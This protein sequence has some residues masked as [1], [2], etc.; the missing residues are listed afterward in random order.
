ML[1]VLACLVAG[2]LEFYLNTYNSFQTSDL[3]KYVLRETVLTIGAFVLTLAILERLLVNR[4]EVKQLITA[5]SLVYLLYA[6]VLLLA[7]ALVYLFSSSWPATLL[8]FGWYLLLIPAAISL[9]LIHISHLRTAR[10]ILLAILIAS[11]IAIPSLLQS[12]QLQAMLEDFS[13]SASYQNTLSSRNW[14]LKPK[15]SIDRFIEQ[16]QDLGP[17]EFAD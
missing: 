13:N 11:P 7:D 6:L 5:V 8:Y 17:G 1:L 9:Y 2:A 10:G 4:W 15:V 12:Q 3:I 16:A 14:H